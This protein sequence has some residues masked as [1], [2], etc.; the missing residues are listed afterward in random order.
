MQLDTIIEQSQGRFFTVVFVKKDNSR[1]TM[2]ARLG[3]TKHLKGGVCTVDREKYI[4]AYEMGAQGYRSINRSTI[5]SVTLDGVTVIDN[6]M[7]AV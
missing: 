4:I 5:I 2:T 7:G 3:V 1:R 6:A